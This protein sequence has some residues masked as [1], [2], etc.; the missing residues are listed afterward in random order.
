MSAE[1]SRVVADAVRLNDR[2]VRVGAPGGAPPDPTLRMIRDERG[3]ITAIEVTCS[4]G[5]HH[6]ILCQY[7]PAQQA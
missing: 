2:R 6:R 7:D 1:R 5:Q 3:V 4:C